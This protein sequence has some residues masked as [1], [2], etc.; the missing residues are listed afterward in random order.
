MN[1]RSFLTALPA[2]VL[3]GVLPRCL[4]AQKRRVSAN[5]L[6]D[7]NW[8]WWRNLPRTLLTESSDPF[9]AVLIQAAA[10][11]GRV[12]IHY[13]GGSNPGATRL[14]SPL[15]GF[16]VEGYDGVYVTAICH[17]RNAESVFRL[18]RIESLT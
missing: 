1:R 18:D 6:E 14:I 15:G 17:E 10:R 7:D 11:R 12:T 5:H 4:D 16:T 8:A 13:S 3:S 9:A 2:L